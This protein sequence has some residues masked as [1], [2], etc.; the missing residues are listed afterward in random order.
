M[1]IESQDLSLWQQ[2]ALN[3]TRVNASITALLA[4]AHCAAK[5]IQEPLLESLQ[6]LSDTDL[7]ED[8]SLEILRV[9]EVCLIRMGRPQPSV[10]NEIVQVLSR[11]Y[12]ARTEKLNRELSQ[13][14]VY[15]EAPDVI[16]KTHALMTTAPTQ[17]EQMHYAF[18]LRNVKAGWAPGCDFS[19][20]WKAIAARNV[21]SLSILNTP[22]YGVIRSG[23]SNRV[24]DTLACIGKLTLRAELEVAGCRL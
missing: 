22:M 12:P 20:S 11:F 8:Q 17:E 24:Y 5:D 14:L 6:R 21:F 15:L 13:L 7:T 3:E 2:R 1:A 10:A 18:V 23:F 19:G 9:L 4:L 16:A